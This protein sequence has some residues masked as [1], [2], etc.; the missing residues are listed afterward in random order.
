M[1][2]LLK[3]LLV[4]S[5]AFSI[6]ACSSA[7]KQPVTEAETVKETEVI[8]EES[9]EVVQEA[10]TQSTE[11][12]NQVIKLGGLKGPTA[13]GMVKLLEDDAQ[14]GENNNYE[15]ILGAAPDEIAP[16]ILKGELDIAA[17][18]ANLAS[19]LYNKSEG[20]IQF[21]A[22][23]TLG[24]LYIAQKGGEDITKVE[25]LKGKT[26]YATGKGATPEYVLTYLLKSHGLDIEKDV[27][28]EW[29]SEPT[30]IVAILK[31]QDDGFAMLPQPFLTAA[32][33]QVEG[34][35]VALD[36]TKEWDALGNGSQLVTA[37]LVAKKEFIE[38][39]KEAVDKFLE[40]YQM[41]TQWLNEN[42]DEGAKLVEKYIDVKEPMAKKAIPFCN[43]T[44][45]EGDDMKS[46]LLGYYN[47]LFELKPEA[48]GGKL[49]EDDFYYAR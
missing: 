1:K 8:T 5:L 9:T 3:S 32:M 6:T 45:I 18:P 23:N 47:V 48:V 38:N 15:F 14:K 35:K 29:K 4:L 28:I 33:A 40:E 13:M 39:N 17:I 49:P 16:K 19:V 20:K 42:L 46:A 11:A 31:N 30:E 25:D 24:I 34:L 12:T 44:Y 10:E 26:I 43:I 27:T 37:G 22:I 41:S 21:L 7:S 36:L 2:K